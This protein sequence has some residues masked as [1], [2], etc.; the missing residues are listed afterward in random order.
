MDPPELA[1]APNTY[2]ELYRNRQ[3]VLRGDYGPWVGSHSVA[4][5]NTP[6]TV[7]NA[8]LSFS[9]AIPKVY[10]VM[11]PG[12]NGTP[13]IKTVFR[14]EL[15]RALPGVNTPY[16]GL[17]YG[18]GTDIGPGNQITTVQFPNDAFH[19]TNEFWAPDIASM[20][21][22]WEEH[23]QANTLGPFE[24]NSPNTIL[25]R[26]R[27]LMIVPQPY[28]PLMLGATLSPRQAWIR[29]STAIMSDNNAVSC[30]PVLEWLI[31]ASCLL[32]PVNDQP[33]RSSV[34][35]EALF[36]PIPDASLAQVR[37]DLVIHDIPQLAGATRTHD[38]AIMHAIAAFQQANVQQAAA[39][40]LERNVARAPKLPSSRFPTTC[41]LLLKV[42]GADTE[43]D[44]PT[45]WHDAASASKSELRTLLNDAFLQ[46]TER[47]GAATSSPPVAT[48]E[49]LD[50]FMGMKLAPPNV[51]D[52]TGALVVFLFTPGS[53][54]HDRQTLVRNDLHDLVYAGTTNPTLADVQALASTTVLIPSD[55]YELTTAL[56]RYSIALDVYFG[57]EHVLCVYFRNW[58]NK[59][60]IGIQTEVRSFIADYYDY[61]ATAYAR[62]ALWISLRMSMYLKQLI[63]SGTTTRLPDLDVFA[64]MIATRDNNFPPIPPR[65][66][67]NVRPPVAA[68]HRPRQ[69]PPPPPPAERVP[70]HQQDV[71]PERDVNPRGNAI[72]KAAFQSLNLRVKACYNVMSPPISGA[73]GVG[74]LCLAYHGTD[75]CFINCGK[76]KSHILLSVPDQDKLVAYFTAVKAARSAAA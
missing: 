23:P 65:F 2:V 24:P 46:M 67:E 20:T 26:T 10:M 30:A 55:H 57:P 51:S 43:L 34:L 21:A 68:D 66:L 25:T 71:N 72:V 42:T 58:I 63:A 52:V 49:V 31:A 40:Q 48:K 11:V 69:P 15:Y 54:E 22:A 33:S 44:L 74:P 61:P 7:R 12:P 6:A 29:V 64:Y 3:D 75:K 9:D 39:A 45:F 50:I 60:W 17:I 13:V 14:P 37:W 4:V 56:Q 62:F 8:M 5:A 35:H 53:L 16:D 76:I 32:P 18:F 19:M 27:N 41:K 28:V 70:V 73:N 1:I 38:Q 59:G 36:S 47:P